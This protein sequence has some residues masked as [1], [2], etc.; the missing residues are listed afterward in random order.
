MDNLP[1]HWYR[2]GPRWT[3]LDGVNWAALADHEKRFAGW[4]TLPTA[5]T[6]PP[7]TGS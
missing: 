3:F 7:T 5:A 6:P 1:A 2:P 4:P